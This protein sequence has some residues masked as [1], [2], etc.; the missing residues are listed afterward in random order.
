M[1]LVDYTIRKFCIQQVPCLSFNCWALLIVLKFIIRISFHAWFISVKS[2]L[3]ILWNLLCV[4]FFIYIL[5]YFMV[6]VVCVSGRRCFWEEASA[7]HHPVPFHQ[8]ARL[9]GALHPYWNAQVPKEG[10]GLQPPVCWAHCCSLQ[11]SRC[12]S[13]RPLC[14]C[15]VFLCTLLAIHEIMFPSVSAGVGRTGTF[16]VIDAMLDMMIAEK[17]VDVFG[18]VTRIRAQRCQMVQTDV[19]GVSTQ[20]TNGRFMIIMQKQKPRH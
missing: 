8:L 3:Y 2:V 17:K 12:A 10:Q 14:F 11:V 15:Y 4:F 13:R 20:S 6:C 16:I 7:P 5:V 19:S 9:R 1:V 18:F